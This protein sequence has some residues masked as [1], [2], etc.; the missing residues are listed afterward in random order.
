VAQ[1]HLR[2]TFIFLNI[3]LMNS[4]EVIVNFAQNKFDSNDRL[5]DEDTRRFLKELLEN[6]V[7]WTKDC[8]KADPDRIRY[9]YF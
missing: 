9:F 7:I 6:L 3:Y 4:S 1:Y 2:K 5:I 8:E